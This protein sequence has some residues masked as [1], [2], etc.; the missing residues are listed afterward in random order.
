[1]TVVAR[2]GENRLNLSGKIDLL[3]GPGRR[4]PAEGTT[5]DDC[6][7]QP[8]ETF[9]GSRHCL[10]FTE[11]MSEPRNRVMITDSG[12]VSKRSV[13]AALEMVFEITRF[14]ETYS[15]LAP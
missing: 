12:T 4:E 14:P 7:E 6:Q 10:I 2:P 11:S 15:L 8:E 9:E 13:A 3:I 5:R 1:M